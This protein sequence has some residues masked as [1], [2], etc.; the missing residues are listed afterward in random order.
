MLIGCDVC[1]EGLWAVYPATPQLSVKVCILGVQPGPIMWS[2]ILH[3]HSLASHH[4][5]AN[6]FAPPYTHTHTPH[7][8][9]LALN[10]TSSAEF[11]VWV[12]HAVSCLK[13]AFPYLLS[14]TGLFRWCERLWIRRT[15]TDFVA[16]D[17]YGNAGTTSV[18]TVRSLVVHQ[19]DH[20][21]S[22][23]E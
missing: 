1:Q 9:N 15:A 22:M 10:H 19:R 21:I 2:R 4:T 14:F 5:P 18:S 3:T 20:P 23:Y 12:T 16:G 8:V 7:L 13:R 11:P 17:V 6:E